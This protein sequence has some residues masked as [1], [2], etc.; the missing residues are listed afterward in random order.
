[1]AIEVRKAPG[2]YDRFERVALIAVAGLGRWTRFV[3]PLPLL[4]LS[5]GQHRSLNTLVA[6]YERVC[7]DERFANPPPTDALQ[8][9]ALLLPGLPPSS[10]ETLVIA[11]GAIRVAEELVDYRRLLEYRRQLGGVNRANARVEEFALSSLEQTTQLACDR[12]DSL[13]T[14]LD[15]S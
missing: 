10:A 15:R 9:L 11:R 8:A 3:R 4:S 2:S 6:W 13:A 14:A 7:A 1:M 12:L 5:D